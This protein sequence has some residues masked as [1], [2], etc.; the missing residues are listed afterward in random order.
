MKAIKV[1][2]EMNRINSVTTAQARSLFGKV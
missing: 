2:I 1:Q